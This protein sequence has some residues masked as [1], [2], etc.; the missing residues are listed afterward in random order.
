MAGRGGDVRRAGAA[1]RRRGLSECRINDQQIVLRFAQLERRVVSKRLAMGDIRIWS[2]PSPLGQINRRIAQTMRVFYTLKEVEVLTEQWR[3]D[4]NQH[5][6][7]SALG[8]RPPAPE[9]IEPS[10]VAPALARLI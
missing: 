10:T 3:R 7:H 6:P 4:Y 1:A 5:W 8:Y 9:M 2:R